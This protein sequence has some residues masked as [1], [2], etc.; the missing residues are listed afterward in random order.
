MI[1]GY[2]R[3]STQDQNQDLQTDA[4]TKAGSEKIFTDKVSGTVSER[5]GLTG[6]KEQL[7]RGDTL[8]V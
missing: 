1:I 7:R 2:A 4:L 6:L 8:V 5:P 3:T